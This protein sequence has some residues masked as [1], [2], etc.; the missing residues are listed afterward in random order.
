MRQS[1][2]ILFISLAVFLGAAT[3]AFAESDDPFLLLGDTKISKACLG[4]FQIAQMEDPQEPLKKMPLSACQN[5]PVNERG[6]TCI[7]V[8]PLCAKDYFPDGACPRP[9]AECGNNIDS[10]WE[11]VKLIGNIG[12]IYLLSDTW[13][14]GGG[15]GVFSAIL[16]LVIRSDP[17]VGPV[18]EN[19]VV[20][21]LGDRSSG[22][23][24]KAVI[25]NDA[26]HYGVSLTPAEFLGAIGIGTTHLGKTHHG[27][28]I[29]RQDYGDVENC[30]LCGYAKANYVAEPPLFEKPRL[31]S[32]ELPAPGKRDPRD[33]FF[34]F[35]DYAHLNDYWAD[36]AKPSID[37]LSEHVGGIEK[38]YNGLPVPKAALDEL[39]DRIRKTCPKPVVIAPKDKY[40]L[41]MRRNLYLK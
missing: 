18:L 13:G 36:G 4:M 23:L 37:C 9:L 35:S 7:A 17:T 28:V 12:G 10:D 8:S 41:E 31:E 38:K 1:T 6:N 11:N 33:T 29:Y 26:L 19:P 20:I 5:I 24:E 21:R 16:S 2:L 15:T 22:G 3:V 32:I 27:A 14:G 34:A 40:F 39:A 25:K 30:A